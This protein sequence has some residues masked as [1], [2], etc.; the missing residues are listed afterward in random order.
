MQWSSVLGSRK[1]TCRCFL[2]S[3]RFPPSTL[4]SP[5]ELK[6]CHDIRRACSSMLGTCSCCYGE[7]NLSVAETNRL[8]R[9][10]KA[11][12]FC[13]TPADKGGKWMAVPFASY[14]DEAY[15]Q[16][17]DAGIYAHVQ[18]D[19]TLWTAQRLRN[20]LSFLNRR[21]F[22]SKRE[23]KALETPSCSKPRHFYLLPKLHKEDR[24]DTLMP[25]GRPIISCWNFSLSPG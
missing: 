17:D 3:N 7:S 11:S 8:T 21:K 16:L 13:I 14:K 2:K 20:V 18:T 1:L 23:A 25:P 9:L 10:E 24:P 15:R 4:V 19:F 5:L 22:L 6:L 12:D